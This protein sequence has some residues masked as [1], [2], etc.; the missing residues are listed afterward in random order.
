[1]NETTALDQLRPAVA[2]AADGIFVVGWEGN[3]TGDPDGVFVREFFAAGGPASGEERVNTTTT[4]FQERAGVASAADGD[5]VVSWQGEESDLAGFDVFARRY[6]RPRGT[7]GDGRQP[8]IRRLRLSRS[9]RGRA[10][11]A[12]V[13]CVSEVCRVR[14]AGVVSVRRVD[15]RRRFR[16]RADRAVLRRGARGRLRLRFS[17]RTLGAALRGAGG[18]RLGRRVRV[19]VLVVGRDAAGGRTALRGNIRLRPRVRRAG[20][21]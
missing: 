1:V 4:F 21:R 9:R 11:R 19:R 20:P 6:A 5:F 8:V 7:T 12:T 10:V 3:G 13:E 2:M 17:R 15:G 16:L 18:R 14:G